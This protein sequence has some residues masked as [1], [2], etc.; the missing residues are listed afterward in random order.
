MLKVFCVSFQLQLAYDWN[1]TA[2]PLTVKLSELSIN[3]TK[4]RNELHSFYVQTK[5]F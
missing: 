2:T 5:Y 4:T 3:R 1:V